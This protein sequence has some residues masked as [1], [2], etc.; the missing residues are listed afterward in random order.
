LDVDEYAK[1][2]G[3]TAIINP[4]RTITRPWKHKC[5]WSNTKG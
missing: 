2:A 3:L 4:Q 1:I 5:K